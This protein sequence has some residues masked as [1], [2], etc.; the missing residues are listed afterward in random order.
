[1]FAKQNRY[2][3]LALSEDR[4]LIRGI[5][6]GISEHLEKEIFCTTDILRLLVAHTSHTS[7]LIIL[8]VDLLHEGLPSLLSV[9]RSIDRSCRILLL[10]S[11][12]DL[13]WC[14]EVLSL[15]DISFFLKPV[16]LPA[17][18][19]LVRSRLRIP[20]SAARSSISA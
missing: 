14:T 12:E 11:H 8:D 16:V 15:G 9:M 13:S 10:L 1:M 5:E 3:V 6:A 19:D 4:K 18:V 2:H 17:V 20:T 7:R